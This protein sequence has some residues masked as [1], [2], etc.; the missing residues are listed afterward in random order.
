MRSG[1]ATLVARLLPDLAE[2]AW[3]TGRIQE[4]TMARLVR[5]AGRSGRLSARGDDG[6]LVHGL[7]GRSARASRWATLAQVDQPSRRRRRWPR[8]ARPGVALSHRHRPDG[9]RRRD[10]RRAP[11]SGQHVVADRQ[12]PARRGPRSRGSSA[13]GRQRAASATELATAAGSSP[14]TPRSASCS[15]RGW[16]S[17]AVSGGR[18]RR[19]PDGLAR[20]CSM[21]A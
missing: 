10:G 16:H 3:N 4:L 20:W 19:S 5:R 21:A 8:G 17:T 18:R 11:A 13:V 9:R 12:D 7:L 2:T 14:R 15:V 6:S 1:D